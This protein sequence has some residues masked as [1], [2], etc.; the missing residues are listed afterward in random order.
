[1]NRDVYTDGNYDLDFYRNA[2]RPGRPSDTY[3]SA[4]AYNSA[5]VQQANSFFVEDAS[6]IR[7]QNVQVGYTFRNINRMSGLRVSLAAQRPLTYFRYNGFTPEISGSPIATGV[8]TST[9]PMQAIYTLGLK[10]SF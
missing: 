7:I 3:P 6:Y 10:M 5:Y 2:W 1:M 9:Y 4:A 8:D